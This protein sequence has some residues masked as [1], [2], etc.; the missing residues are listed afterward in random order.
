MDFQDVALLPSLVSFS[1][2]FLINCGGGEILDTSTS[3]ITMDGGDQGHAPCKIILL[4]QCLFLCQSNFMEIKRGWLLSVCFNW[5]IWVV[6]LRLSEV[7]CP[8]ETVRGGVST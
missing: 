1:T 8:L 5:C 2:T 7:G 3:V 4:Q 6:P